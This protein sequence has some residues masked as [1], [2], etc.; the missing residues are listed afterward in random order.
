MI[1]KH[2]RAIAA[3]L[4]LLTLFAGASI[5]GN[6]SL[7]NTQPVVRVPVA[8]YSRPDFADIYLNGKF[9]GSTD[10]EQRLTPG[11]HVIEIRREGYGSWRRELTVTA[12]NPTRV[13]ALL[14]KTE[15]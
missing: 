9:I 3:A 2:W 8:I 1:K 11:V 14:S 5:A 4:L 6:N 10:V 15:K 7:P 12:G 13:V